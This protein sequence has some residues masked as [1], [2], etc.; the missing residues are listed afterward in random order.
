MRKGIDSLVGKVVHA[1][2]DHV[3]ARDPSDL[4]AVLDALLGLDH[5]NGQGRVVLRLESPVEVLDIKVELR[6]EGE[7]TFSLTSKLQNLSFGGCKLT[8]G[9][10]LLYLTSVLAISALLILGTF[11]ISSAKKQRWA[12]GTHN[13]ALSSVIQ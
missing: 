7:W 6:G 11:L 13:N 2:K 10:C 4:L 3:D 9:R 5:G 1:N 12:C 8:M